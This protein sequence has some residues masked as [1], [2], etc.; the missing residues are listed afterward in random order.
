MPTTKTEALGQTAASV[1]NDAEAA[2]PFRIKKRIGTSV[3]EVNVFFDPDAKESMKDKI[4]RLIR[5]DM[6]LTSNGAVNSSFYTS[7]MH[8]RGSA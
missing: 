2:K 7:R 4:L 3:Y 6:N 8:E 5:N 1:H